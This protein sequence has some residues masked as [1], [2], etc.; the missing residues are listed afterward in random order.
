MSRL[1]FLLNQP[2]EDAANRGFGLLLLAG[3]VLLA[4]V[5]VVGRTPV[6]AAAVVAYL[7]S[8]P[9]YV[10]VRV[11]RWNESLANVDPATGREEASVAG[12]ERGRDEGSDE[13]G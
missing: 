10:A 6:L 13:S 7:L 1:D 12:V 2:F 5:A 3:V 11:R 9:A 4:L 8:L